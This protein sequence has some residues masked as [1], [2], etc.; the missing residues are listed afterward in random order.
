MKC[1]LWLCRLVG[2][3]INTNTHLVRGP[4]AA[5]LLLT[6]SPHNLSCTLALATIHWPGWCLRLLGLPLM[7]KAMIWGFWL[8]FILQFSSSICSISGNIWLCQLPRCISNIW[9][10]KPQGVGSSGKGLDLCDSSMRSKV[11]IPLGVNNS[12]GPTR[13]WG[14]SITWSVWKGHFTQI[15]S[16]PDKSRYM[17]WSYLGGV[18]CHKKNIYEV[19]ICLEKRTEEM[20]VF[21]V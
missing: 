17:K 20:W 21:C 15:R 11:W 9:N 6:L 7:V 3:L 5:A 18:S 10:K 19:T 14:R 8:Y 16:L 2:F 1:S 12:L 13:R 4:A